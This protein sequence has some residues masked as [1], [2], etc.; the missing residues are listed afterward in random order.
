MSKTTTQ[1][2]MTLDKTHEVYVE[3]HGLAK[4]KQ[5]LIVK[6]DIEKMEEIVNKEQGLVVTLMKLEEIR[7][8]VVEQLMEEHGIT[9]GETLEDIM[10]SLPE[11]DRLVIG[12][13]KTRLIST[14]K[15]VED[16]TKLNEHLILQALEVIELNKNIMTSMGEE[17][18]Y[19][20]TGKEMDDER[21]SLFDVKV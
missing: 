1:L 2:I 21:K 14:V 15:N 8:R 10:K 17:T 19:A 3:L 9:E 6:G 13:S 11:A 7:G 4:E 5:A 18:K 16:E 20:K 12:R